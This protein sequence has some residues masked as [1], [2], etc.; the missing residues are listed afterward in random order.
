[1]GVARVV[2]LLLNV[3]AIGK[4]VSWMGNEGWGAIVIIIVLVQACQTVADLGLSVGTINALVK[5]TQRGDQASSNRVLATHTGISLLVSLIIVIPFSICFSTGYIKSVHQ[6]LFGGLFYGITLG[7]FVLVLITNGQSAALVSRGKYSFIALM[8]MIGSFINTGVSLW[9]VY[10]YRH[11]WGFMAG[12]FVATLFTAFVYER[13]IRQLGYGGQRVGLFWSEFADVTAYVKRSW[14]SNSA[15]FASGLDR[16]VLNGVVGQARLGVYDQAVRIPGVLGS[17]MPLAQV[18]PAEIARV[19][20]EGPKALKDA[21]WKVFPATLALLM[22]VLLIPSA[23]SESYLRLVFKSYD[24][25]M[26]T[27]FVLAGID[28][29]YAAYGSLFSV[30][31]NATGKPHITAPFVWFMLLGSALLAYPA[32]TMFG[33]IGVAGARVL[34][35]LT[36]FYVIE[37]ATK[38]YLIPDLNLRLALTK[39]LTISIVAFAFWAIGYQIFLALH[40]QNSP[41]VS[42]GISAILSYLFILVLVAT[43]VVR[44]PS[45]LEQTLPK[46]ARH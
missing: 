12:N 30:F 25:V 10:Q 3:W 31:A 34:L 41:F 27:L 38:K 26:A 35:Q 1:M 39:K 32:A 42:L 46:F 43:R 44:L 20:M 7:L 15:Q 33:L 2:A 37:W 22:A 45:R 40:L 36:Q 24:P 8:S 4:Y 17:T 9:L 28:A 14:V 21:Y 13:K 18:F 11:P 16:L 19:N 23:F 29:A 5:S 6:D